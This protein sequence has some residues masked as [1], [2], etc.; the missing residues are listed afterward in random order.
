MSMTSGLI[1]IK[2][3]HLDKLPEI[4]AFYQMIDMEENQSVDDWD[5]ALAIVT[6][7]QAPAPGNTS[8]KHIVWSDKGWTLIEDMT[9]IM[10]ANE[11]ALLV[12]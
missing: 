6:D 1:A 11:E 5:E 10:C 8:E 7:L 12:F 9:L 2:G 4:L 3:K